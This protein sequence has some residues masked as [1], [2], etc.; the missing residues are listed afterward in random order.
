MILL[1]EMNVKNVGIIVANEEND[2]ILLDLELSIQLQSKGFI[3]NGRKCFS[4]VL[5]VI[6]IR[7]STLTV[8]NV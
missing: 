2:N 4:K 1:R 8:M 7:N 6:Y 5:I 3:I